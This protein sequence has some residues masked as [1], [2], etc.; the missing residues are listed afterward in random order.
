MHIVFIISTGGGPEALLKNLAPLFVKEGIKVSI[1]L[2]KVKQE[3][4]HEFPSHFN[5]AELTK[6]S[7]VPYY[8]HRFFG[9][10][11]FLKPQIAY[12]IRKE[13]ENRLYRTLLAINKKESIDIVEVTEGQFI[14][15]IAKNWKVVTRAHGSDWS[16]RLFCEDQDNS[17]GRFL[18][19]W[20]RRQH[21][22]SVRNFAIS[23]H[24]KDHL[25]QICNLPRETIQFL[26]YPIPI[27]K[28]RNTAPAV[29]EE[30]PR[31]APLLLS[32]GRLEKRKGMDT[33]VQAMPI[34]W[35]HYPETRLLLLGKETEF[36]I[37]QLRAMVPTDK[38]E[39]IIYPGFV[40]YSKIPSYYKAATLYISASQYETFGYT[41]LEGMA[42]GT[43]VICTDRGAMPEL[44]EH[45][46]NGLVT[47]Y[48]N[49]LTLADAI[50]E[51]LSSEQQ[52]KVFI[53]AGYK[54]AEAYDLP[55]MGQSILQT[56]KEIINDY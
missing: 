9:H 39:Y 47:A 14:N 4:F 12:I 29:I 44:I 53:E 45:N 40:H 1:I 19:K 22:Q 8:L 30:L 7:S 34:V 38:R 33:L 3:N 2:K 54:K 28:F 52:R 43:P 25:T 48:G 23:Q 15:K 37:D 35:K 17:I 46:K 5:L 24:T 18:I 16:F 41:L 31:D 50:V 20:Q 10:F 51:L 27:E 56:Y 21:L 6:G 11:T 42:S 26:P 55:L 49:P 13:K 36:T 32:I